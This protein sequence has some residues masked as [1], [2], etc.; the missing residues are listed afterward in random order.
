VN[1]KKQFGRDA[2]AVFVKPPSIEELKK[3][4]LGRNTET[5]ESLKKRLDR[6]VFE[7]GFE[8]KFDITLVNDNLETAK[9]KAINL[10]K[11]FIGK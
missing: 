3:R 1:I 9:A 8:E 11:E 7:L 6:A 2:L 5:E 4:L 10:V